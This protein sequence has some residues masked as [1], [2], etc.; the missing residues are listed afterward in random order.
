MPRIARMKSPADYYHIMMRGINKERIF[1][2]QAHK[3]FM[4]ELLETQLKENQASLV[5]Y[6]IMDNHLHLVVK[7]ELK[8][9]STSLK[10]VNIR[11]AMRLDKEPNRVGHVFQDRY[12]SK[13]IHDDQHLLQAIRYVHNY[14][15]KANRVNNPKEYQWSSYGCYVNKK[16]GILDK[17]YV[18][19]ILEIAGEL[20]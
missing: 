8:D 3:K 10:K 11:F 18:E 17:S 12:K 5:A 19:E 14:P 4:E 7:G 20:D 13:I 9:I 6:C 1:I 16:V 15:V 2:D